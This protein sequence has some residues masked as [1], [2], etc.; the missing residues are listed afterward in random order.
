MTT[1]Q[2]QAS[3]LFN[4]FV[5]F[6]E[7]RHTFKYF[8]MWAMKR[9]KILSLIP[10]SIKTGPYQLFLINF[11]TFTRKVKNAAMYNNWKLFDNLMKHLKF[12][13]I[14]IHAPLLA[15]AE[16]IMPKVLEQWCSH[17]DCQAVK[18]YLQTI[19]QLLP[20]HI[21]D[22]QILKFLSKLKSEECVC[23]LVLTN[24]KL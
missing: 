11:Y 2:P 17:D 20:R 5:K 6:P 19:V 18:S 3:I 12:S 15:L 16:R 10:K 24:W 14:T 9:S 1:F 23:S 8:H 22:G 21:T 13:R 7:I 4:F